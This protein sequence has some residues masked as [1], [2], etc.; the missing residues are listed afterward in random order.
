MRNRFDTPEA[1]SLSGIEPS[2]HGSSVRPKVAA[3]GGRILVIDDT[4]LARDT[5]ATVLESHGFDV[6]LAQDGE[7]GVAFYR[8]LYRV[9]DA[10]VLDMEMPGMD[11]AQ[12]FVQLKAL[13]PAV[14]VVLCSGGLMDP[15]AQQTMRDGAIAFLAKPFLPDQLVEIVVGAVATKAESVEGA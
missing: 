6:V 14:K 1:E 12:T 5:I 4:A 2:S 3:P 9:I 8:A 10:V 7:E 11:G 13:N 15:R